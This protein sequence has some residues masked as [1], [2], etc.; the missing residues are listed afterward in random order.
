[1]SIQLQ[2]GPQPTMFTSSGA[3]QGAFT[4]LAFNVDDIEAEVSDLRAREVTFEEY[5]IPGL[6]MVD[7]IGDGDGDGDGN[8]PSKGSRERG[9]SG[10]VR[11][12]EAA[13]SS[14][15]TTREHGSS[16]LGCTTDRGAPGIVSPPRQPATYEEI[17]CPTH[18]WSSPP[19]S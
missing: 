18:R 14:A 17:P 13:S 15:S 6:P 8:Y 10:R 16:R 7:G 5:D 4:Q 19:T 11:M 2:F 3:S 1:M 9:A 12:P